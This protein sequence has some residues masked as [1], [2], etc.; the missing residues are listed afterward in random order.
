MSKFKYIK[1]VIPVIFMVFLQTCNQ[2]RKLVKT[3]MLEKPVVELKHVKLRGKLRVLTDYNSTNYFIYKG[4]TM[5]FQYEMLKVLA[6]HLGVKLEL[7]VNNDLNSCFDALEN[8]EV[9]L[10]GMNLAVY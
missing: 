2:N 3:G 1:L 7:I 4:R 9:D 5:G 6:D 10:I 8:G